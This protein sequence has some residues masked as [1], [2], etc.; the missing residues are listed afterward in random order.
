MNTNHHHLPYRQWKMSNPSAEAESRRKYTI[1]K[2]ASFHF[3]MAGWYFERGNS[4]SNNAIEN[5]IN[6]VKLAAINGLWQSNVFPR[7]EGGVQ[8][9]L[10]AGEHEVEIA[11]EPNGTS[12]ITYDFEGDQKL[13]AEGLS[14]SQAMST[15]RTVAKE[16]CTFEQF[17]RSTSTSTNVDLVLL[18]ASLQVTVA[19]QFSSSNVAKAIRAQSAS[20]SEYFTKISLQS[21]QF[22]GE[23]PLPIYQ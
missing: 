19:S 7:E 13:E 22:F 5:A 12:A 10:Y 9:E 17:T 21:H 16:I 8:V 15:L 6:F 2:T 4:I 1:K 3:L 14:F 23:S 11:I 18:H 20:T